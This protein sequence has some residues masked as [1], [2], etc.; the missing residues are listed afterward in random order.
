VKT[1]LTLCLTL[2]T[3]LDLVAS[4][5]SSHLDGCLDPDAITAALKELGRAKPQ[6]VNPDYIQKMWPAPIRP[7]EC[8]DA[9]TCKLWVR[10]GRIINGELECVDVFEFDSI[11]EHS[12]HQQELTSVTIHYI[13]DSRSDIIAL[14][15]SL[16]TSIDV[17][18]KELNS[19][20]DRDVESLKWKDADRHPGMDTVGLNINL[21]PAG[22]RWRLFF[23]YSIYVR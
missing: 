18:Q 9:T 10:E 7:L 22:S 19:I 5:K 21:T 2:L 6:S 13:A 3:C 20:G 11:P 4:S 1:T 8:E 16:A 14:A 15:K 23:A 17:P 12:P